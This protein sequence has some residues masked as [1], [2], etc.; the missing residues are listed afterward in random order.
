[1]R[2]FKHINLLRLMTV[3][4]H[5]SWALDVFHGWNY[6]LTPREMKEENKKGEGREGG[7]RRGEGGGEERTGRE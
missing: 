3:G 7:E 4:V 2:I 1:M 6:T 5:K